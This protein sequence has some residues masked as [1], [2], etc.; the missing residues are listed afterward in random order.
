MDPQL[1]LLPASSA[2]DIL[3]THCHPPPLRPSS[4]TPAAPRSTPTDVS[5]GNNNP[6][7]EIAHLLSDANRTAKLPFDPN[8]FAP[9]VLNCF[10]RFGD[11]RSLGR[12]TVFLGSLWRA[13]INE[14]ITPT[15][16]APEQHQEAATQWTGARPSIPPHTP[17]P[18][19]LDFGTDPCFTRE[20][21][22]AAKP[23]ATE[24]RFRCVL[25]RRRDESE[26]VL[27]LVDSETEVET[28]ALPGEN[29]SSRLSSSSSR[30]VADATNLPP[31]TIPASN[32]IPP[33]LIP[34]RSPP[35]TNATSSSP[36]RKKRR[37]S[38]Y[39]QSRLLS[40]AQ[41]RQNHIQAEQQRRAKIN[42]LFEEI[43][44]LT[45][46]ILMGYCSKRELIA[47]FGCHLRAVK[48]GNEVLRRYLRGLEEGVG[49]MG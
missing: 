15:P 30:Q 40:A 4:S 49:A 46:G 33:P 26:S 12:L 47:R 42:A 48:E 32:C 25:T 43:R 35:P 22:K 14:I 21:F 24:P 39:T 36:P 6:W 44:G 37:I 29:S 23:G 28:V 27:H 2:I 17:K 1:P 7:F 13:E 41:K 3:R 8:T 9:T 11:Q 5:F 31:A 45:P 18:Q 34:S 20:G 10:P 16:P 19:G 38:T